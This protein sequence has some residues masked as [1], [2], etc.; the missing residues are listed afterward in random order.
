MLL[1]L[2]NLYSLIFALF[3]KIERMSQELDS[4][5]P[6]LTLNATIIPNETLNLSESFTTN[7][8]DFCVEQ[9]IS[10][11]PCDTQITLPKS[12]ADGIVLK[13]RAASFPKRI[14]PKVLLRR[15]R[16]V[17]FRA[18]NNID[19]LEKN[20]TT[21]LDSILIGL[22]EL[23][24]LRSIRIQLPVNI[25]YERENDTTSDIYDYEYTFDDI[26]ESTTGAKMDS[27]FEYTNVDHSS[28]VTDYSSTD[29]TTTEGSTATETSTVTESSETPFTFDDFSSNTDTTTDSE[30]TLTD[31]T[32][33]SDY[34][35][36][37]FNIFEKTTEILNKEITDTSSNEMTETT[38]YTIDTSTGLDLTDTTLKYTT[39]YDVVET[40][41][42]YTTSQHITKANG[43]DITTETSTEST[44]N[45]KTI[46][47]IDICPDFTFNCTVNCNGKKVKQVFFM[48]N[49][50]IVKRVCYAKVCPANISAAVDPK[51]ATN[52]TVDLVY[53]DD[54][55][56]KMYN[57]SVPTKKKLLKLCWETM[58][59]Q[60]LVKLT[61]MDLVRY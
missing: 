54:N 28:T 5:K 56:R 36:P 22:K 8:P 34:G 37:Y 53:V 55:M 7:L 59:G 32:S 42:P 44:L 16:Q 38:T 1:N 4:L 47:N 24:R 46:A 43:Y 39:D 2:L 12:L 14:A 19:N 48:S 18:S 6:T 52:V 27:T 11:G 45:S 40:A 17:P 25:T 15:P 58:F 31:M 41:S 61:M 29:L 60:E 33:F 35:S 23:E 13:T 20:E 21:T 10:C 50:T 51:N 26:T 30:T 49:C 3:S 57:L 9:E